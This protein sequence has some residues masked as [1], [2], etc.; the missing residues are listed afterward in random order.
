MN[1]VGINAAEP[2]AGLMHGAQPRLDRSQG[3]GG[4]GPRPQRSG[5]LTAMPDRD[6]PPA[7]GLPNPMVIRKP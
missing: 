4:R 3:P 7:C 6:L 1:P 2:R 5:N